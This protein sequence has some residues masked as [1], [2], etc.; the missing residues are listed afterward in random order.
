[1]NALRIDHQGPE[2]AY[3][4]VTRDYEEPKPRRTRRQGYSRRNRLAGF[5]GIHR[6]RSRRWNW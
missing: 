1:M 4:V 2:I 3:Q 6:R 5:N